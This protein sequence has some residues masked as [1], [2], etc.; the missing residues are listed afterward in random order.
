[1]FMRRALATLAV[2]LL[3]AAGLPDASAQSTATPV[4]FVHGMG[5]SAADIGTVQF[6]DLLTGLA[7]THPAP[8]PEK[9]VCQKDAQPDRP[10]DGS[11]CVFRY[12][13]DAAETDGGPNDSQSAVEDNADKLASELKEISR[14]AGGERVVLIG[15]S[16]GGAIIRTFLAEHR[17]SAERLVEAV[18]LIDAV[19]SGSWGYAFATEVPRRFEGSLGDRLKELMRSMAASS[20]SVDFARPA[21]RDL[22]PRSELFRRIAPMRLPRNISYYTFWGDIRVVIERGLLHYE[23]PDFKLPSLGDLG[24]LGGDPDPTVLPEL[25]GQRFSPAVDDDNVALDV[26]HRTR[27]ALDGAVIRDLISACGQKPAEDSPDCA[28]L[29]GKHFSIPNTHTSVPTTMARVMVDEPE[30]GGEVSLLDAVMTA[31]GRH[32]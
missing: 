28:K 21:T 9:D 17:R 23:L 16:M 20:A 29:A 1:M 6:A 4:V 2:G 3:V 5:S 31:I 30:L 32:T 12:V 11:P 19:A 15:Y 8:G 25:G 7:E 27:I 13:E 26:P 22:S 18:V 14:N 24:L 10:W